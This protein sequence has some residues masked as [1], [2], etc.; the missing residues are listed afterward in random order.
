MHNNQ[1][2]DNFFWALL[3]CCQP[4]GGMNHCVMLPLV[5]IIWYNKIKIFITL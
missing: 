5:D 2:V 3:A 4:D 1:T